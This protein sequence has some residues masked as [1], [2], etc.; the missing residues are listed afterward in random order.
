MAQEAAGALTLM[1]RI[2]LAALLA[3]SLPVTAAETSN[4]A[5]KEIEHLI[6]HLASSGCQFNRNGTWY[7]AA[8]AVSHLKR[9]YDYLSDRNLVPTA[10]AFIE[11]GASESSSSGK[12]YLVKCGDKPEVRCSE[13]FHAE[14]ARFREESGDAAKRH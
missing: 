7:D 6:D 2:L 12:P 9:K 8:R 1:K 10:E 11:N 4:A 3:F 5:K 13:W 14:L